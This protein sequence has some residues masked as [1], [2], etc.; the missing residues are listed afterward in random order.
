VFSSTAEAAQ[1][2]L[3]APVPKTMIPLNVTHQAIVTDSIH[4]RLTNSTPHGA[5][6][7]VASSQLRHTLSTLISFF[8]ES[9]KNAF[10]FIDGPPLHD[11]LTI[12]Y[13]SQPELFTTRRYRV[14][15]ELTGTHSSGQTV[16][17][18]WGYSK[19]DDT[20]G[21]TGK[22][23]EV[24]EDLD[25]CTVSRFC[26]CML[27]GALARSRHFSSFFLIAWRDA[28]GYRH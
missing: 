24:A 28:T 11:A 12:A 20:W 3:N 6:S 13:V 9:Y 5:S 10:S 17:D 19:V 21:R 16:A 1:I 4:A 27:T 8:K 26:L 23:C 22:N 14:D 15:V 2:V 7:E 25:V 18:V